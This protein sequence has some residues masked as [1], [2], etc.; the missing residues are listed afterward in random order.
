MSEWDKLWNNDIRKEVWTAE[1]DWFIGDWV[2]EV[3]TEGDRLKKEGLEHYA[4]AVEYYECLETIKKI[5]DEW[6]EQRSD[7]H[8]LE[9]DWHYKDKYFALR[10]ALDSQFK[11]KCE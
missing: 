8:G 2:A 3:K 11:E 7:A 5:V 10:D 9:Y 4:I 1:H 6:G